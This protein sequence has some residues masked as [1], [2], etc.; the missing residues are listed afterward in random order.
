MSRT[1]GLLGN[2]TIYWGVLGGGQREQQNG[3]KA[4][5]FYMTVSGVVV[6]KLI[7]AIQTDQELDALA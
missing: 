4:S 7:Q 3:G 5:R 1:K 6:F 2:H